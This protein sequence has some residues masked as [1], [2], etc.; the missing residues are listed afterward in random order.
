VSDEARIGAVSPAGRRPYRPARPMRTTAT[1]P[2]SDPALDAA[3]LA[4]Q[5]ARVARG[6]ARAA[7]L[8]ISDGLVTNICLILGMAG[9]H[10]SPATIRLAGFASLLAG[11]LSMAA[12]EWVSVRSQ[13]ALYGGLV[14]KIR[15]LVSRNPRLM[16]DE[17]SAHLEAAGFARATARSAPAELA[18]DE[19]RFLAFTAQIVFGISPAGLGSPVTAATTS[20]AYFAG[21]ALVPLAPW[22]LLTGAPAVSASIG[23]TALASGIVG[24][25]IAHSSDNSK[26]RGALRQLGII[27]AAAAVTYGIGKLFGS[28]VS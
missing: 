18:L 1:G 20:L 14:T 25:V 27:L 19:E 22:W 13:T 5:V 7:V 11:A 6:G 2:S 16:L 4:D 26:G 8:G 9:A 12:G 17:L 3:E 24:A 23:L 10:A 15:R 21:G 28:T